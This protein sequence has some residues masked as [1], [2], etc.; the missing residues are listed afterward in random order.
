MIYLDPP[1]LK[2]KRRNLRLGTMLK[3]TPSSDNTSQ[4]AAVHNETAVF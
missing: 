4:V 3:T 1:Q 2:Y